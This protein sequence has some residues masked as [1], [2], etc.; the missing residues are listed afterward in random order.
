MSTVTVFNSYNEPISGLS[1][2]GYNAGPI[3]GWSDGTKSAKY[4]PSALAVPRSKH[5][6]SGK[7][8]FATDKDNPVHI[9]W[10]SFT[11]DCVVTMPDPKSDP[12]SLDDDLI[13]YLTKNQAILVTTR[14]FVINTFA[15]GLQE[16]SKVSAE[17]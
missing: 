2:S 14:G 3:A 8:T 7:A 16:T 17:A 15:I 1:V 11:G 10:N 12:V 5:E 6:E 4:T 13:L 9:P